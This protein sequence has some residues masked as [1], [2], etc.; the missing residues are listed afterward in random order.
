MVSFNTVIKIFSKKGE[1]T[2]W[3]YIEI[4]SGIA[5]KLLPQNKKTFRVKGNLDEYYFKQVALHPMGNGNFILPL[6]SETRK[7]IYKKAG[8]TLNVKI[9]LDNSPVL[10]SSELLQFLREEPTAFINFK[11]LTPSHQKYYSNWINN[12]K[13]Y[14]TKAKRIA[15][16]VN[17]LL[18]NNH[19]GEMM[20]EFKENK[21][22]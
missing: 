19:F 18:K 11:K 13:T 21:Q 17:A 8:D 4:T 15:M 7:N 16:A 22:N 3:T 5:R 10:I 20:R 6:N 14:E 12:A 2:G 9:E 1:K